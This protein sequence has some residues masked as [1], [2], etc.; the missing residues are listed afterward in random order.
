MNVN[1]QSVLPLFLKSE[2]K[3]MSS[4][5]MTADN[6]V[7]SPH[8]CSHTLLYIRAE[9]SHALGSCHFIQKLIN[10]SLNFFKVSEN[11]S[12]F[13]LHQEAKL[14]NVLDVAKQI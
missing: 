6:T 10:P 13:A 7:A 1:S 12:F 9:A 5:N 4:Q 8:Y 11:R 14:V 2:I 3:E